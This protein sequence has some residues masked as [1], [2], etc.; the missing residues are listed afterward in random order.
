MFCFGRPKRRTSSHDP[1][2]APASHA[3][4]EMYVVRRM[5]ATTTQHVDKTVGK[6]VSNEDSR[7]K[8]NSI[9]ER[10]DK[11]VELRRLGE[12]EHVLETHERTH[13]RMECNTM[14]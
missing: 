1:S 9:V 5:V 14:Q 13:A 11:P 10:T 2:P 4:Y 7:F 3:L 6:W 12:R 8:T